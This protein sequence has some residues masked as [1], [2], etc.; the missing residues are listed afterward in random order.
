MNHHPH[1]LKTLLS[2]KNVSINEKGANGNC[3]LIDAIINNDFKSVILL[4]NF[5]RKNKINM[6][7]KDEQGNTPLILSYKHGYME[8]FNYLISHLDINEKDSKGFSILYYVII[9]KDINILF[10]LLDNNISINNI[11]NYENSIFQVLINKGY[12]DILVRIMN[13]P[14]IKED[15]KLNHEN[16]KGETLLLTIIKNSNNDFKS[17]KNK[18]IKYF[19]SRGSNINFVNKKGET[20]LSV[21]I[22]SKSLSQI[23]TLIE[24]GAIININIILKSIEINNPSMFET[25]INSDNC[26]NFSNNE[27]ILIL[28]KLFYNTFKYVTKKY[29]NYINSENIN[30]MKMLKYYIKYLINNNDSDIIYESEIIK[31]IIEIDHTELLQ[32]LK[33]NGIDLTS[34]FSTID[35][36]DCT[37]LDYAI[38]IEKRKA[39]I[40]IYITYYTNLYPN[41]NFCNDGYINKRESK[42]IA[43]Y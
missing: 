15:V 12:K 38:S 6:N 25:L 37:P 3:P 13:I 24:N 42:K 7:V 20:A 22:K 8:I 14:K 36:N 2:Y 16:I 1:L 26:V 30:C 29:L 11:D 43:Y 10:M 40:Y 28:N 18:I 5:G 27:K 17:I 32:Y 23:T 39:F 34:P 19:L 41:N 9:K 35:D 21:A 31:R 4:I 33:N